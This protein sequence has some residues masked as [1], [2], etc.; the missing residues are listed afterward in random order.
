MKK[1]LLCFMAIILITG[2]TTKEKGNY[3]EGTYYGTYVD[4]YGGKENVASTVIYVDENGMIKSV[5]IDTT[6][7]TSEGGNTTKKALGND[8]GMKTKNPNAAGEWYEQINKLEK[9]IV[10]KQEISFITIKEDGKT[11]SVSGCTIVIDAIYK[12]LENAINKA[13]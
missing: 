13:K 12:A 7:D 4:T 2:C 3:K 5:F 6:Y 11:D 9:T 8:Y 10:E 1:A